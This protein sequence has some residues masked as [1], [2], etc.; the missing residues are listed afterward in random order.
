M[1][2]LGWPNRHAHAPF[3]AR[4]SPS[5]QS[6][7][8]LAN[9]GVLGKQLSPWGARQVDCVASVQLCRDHHISGFPSLRIFRKVCCRTGP[10]PRHH[11]QQLLDFGLP[12]AC[13][14]A[15]AMLS[16]SRPI[17][18]WAAWRLL[19]KADMAPLT[20][21]LGASCQPLHTLLDAAQH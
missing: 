16:M 5:R 13:P 12:L 6:Q 2:A 7:C 15:L 19:Q 8:Q 10:K 20:A 17:R 11:S 1:L 3:Q 18:L 21:G 14:P 4:H 9:I